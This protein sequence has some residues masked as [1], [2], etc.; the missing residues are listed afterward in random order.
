MDSIIWMY[1]GAVVWIALIA[2]LL[3]PRT[4]STERDDQSKNKPEGEA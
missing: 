2:F 3:W 1:P 4:K